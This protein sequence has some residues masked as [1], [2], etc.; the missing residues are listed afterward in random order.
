MIDIKDDDEVLTTNPDKLVGEVAEKRAGVLMAL[1]RVGSVLVNNRPVLLVVLIAALVA[2]MAYLYPFSF[3]TIDNSRAVLLNAAQS[4]ILVVGM[5]LLMIGGT[6]DLSIGSILALTGV[7]SALLVTELGANP[8][9]A[10]LGGLA[11][12][13]LCGLVNGLI[14]TKIRINALIATLA[15]AGVLRGVTQLI[16]GTGVGV[17]GPEFARVGQST[18]LGLQS[19]FWVMVAVATVGGLLVART[20]FFREYYFVG[21]NSRAARLSGMRPDRL[22]LIAFVIMGT[23]AGVAGVL[24]AAR[25]NS[26]VV[27]AGIG[28]ELQ[29]ITAAVLGGATLRGGEGTILGGVLGVVFIAIVNNA[30]II[31]RVDA[32]WQNIVVGVVLLLAVSLDRWKKSTG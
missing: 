9:L 21:S 32:F 6:F 14:V 10:V 4:G 15:M 24:G 28:V 20:R 18:W 26:A 19:P 17:I 3:P 7:S 1:R 30:L 11:V 23:L 2:Y 25:L 8:L 27:S 5:M 31:M 29:V 13:A 22:I 16:S 12:G